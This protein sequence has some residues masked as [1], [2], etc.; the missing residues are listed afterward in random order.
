METDSMVQS[1]FGSTLE[2]DIEGVRKRLKSVIDLPSAALYTHRDG[3]TLLHKAAGYGYPDLVCKIILRGADVNAQDSEGQAPL[4]F[5]CCH[6]HKTT[7]KKLLENGALVNLQDYQGWTPLRSALNRRNFAE[8]R[9][10][11]VLLLESGADPYLKSKSGRNC[12]FDIVEGDHRLFVIL[13]HLFNLLKSHQYNEQQREQIIDRYLGTKDFFKI[14]KE[15]DDRLPTIELLTTPRLIQSRL[16][17]CDNITP[18]HRAAGHDYRGIAEFLVKKGVNVNTTDKNGRIPLHYAVDF[19]HIE[20]IKFLVEKGSN[21]NAQDSIGYS[22][23]HI[24]ATKMEHQPCLTLYN[25]G[26]DIHL[27]CRDGKIPFDLAISGA[28]KDVLEPPREEALIPAG[29]P[30]AIYVLEDTEPAIKRFDENQVPSYESIFDRLMMN[31]DSDQPLFENPQHNLKKI[32]LQP[33]DSRYIILETYMNQT[34]VKHN[35]DLGGRFRSY[36]IIKI[37]QILNKKVWSIYRQM[38][39]RLKNELG[40]KNERLLFHGSTAVDEI[41]KYGFDERYAQNDGMFG[42]GIYFA[43]NSSKSNQYVFGLGNGC[44]AHSLKSCHVCERKMIVA[45]VALG[46]SFV[47][48]EPMPDCPHGPPGYWSVTGEPGTTGDLLYPEYVIYKSEQAYPLFVIKYR[49]KP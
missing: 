45:Q 14:I 47:S 28:V 8:Y 25:L 7:A 27:R 34:I 15:G 30:N 10:L 16:I 20:M 38:C 44:R 5:A 42:A 48:K 41:H 6:N 33:E 18:L 21:I 2:N 39:D 24:A 40:Y 17:E 26:A 37:E 19:G 22:P 29:S 43:K 1:L 31:S 32:L 11:I 23:L 35:Q 4:H 49:I 13:E 3:K 36:E 46:R 9:E 12:F